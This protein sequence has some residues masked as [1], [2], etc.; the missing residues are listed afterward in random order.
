MLFTS[1]IVVNLLQLGITSGF[2]VLIQFFSILLGIDEYNVMK[3]EK[4]KI[5]RC[6]G[7]NV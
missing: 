3:M 2:P 7:M 1:G 4:I 5:Q 6:L